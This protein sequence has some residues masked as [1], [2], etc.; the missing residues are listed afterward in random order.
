[1]KLARQILVVI[2]VVAVI[3]ALGFA[4][5]HSP[6][7]SLVSDR[8]HGFDSRNLVPPPGA[9]VTANLDGRDGRR[10]G[11][12]D[13]TRADDL[14]QSLVILGLIVAGVI[15]VDRLRRQ[16]SPVISGSRSRP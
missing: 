8:G 13:I 10:D 12:F 6:A 3:M 16:R 15:V 11:G 4:M 2:G 1:M 14:A 5:K 9:P 7:A